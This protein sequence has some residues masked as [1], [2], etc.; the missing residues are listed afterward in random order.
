[1]NGGADTKITIELYQMLSFLIGVGRGGGGGGGGAGG[2]P[3]Q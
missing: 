3:P 2:Q 1:M